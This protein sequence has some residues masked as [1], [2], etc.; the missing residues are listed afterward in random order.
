L[1]TY[2]IVLEE[3]LCSAEFVFV[4]ISPQIVWQL[5]ESGTHEFTSPTIQVGFVAT[6]QDSASK[7]LMWRTEH[8][9]TIIPVISSQYLSEI[10]KFHVKA[11]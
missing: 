2:I 4:S 3:L 8:S 11:R 5:K 6:E 9:T 10:N 7:G 1:V